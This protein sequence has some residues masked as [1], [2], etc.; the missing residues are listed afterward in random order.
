MRALQQGQTAAHDYFRYGLAKEI[1]NYLGQVEATVKDVYLYE[2]ES[3]TEGST[4]AE[5]EG[6]RRGC[7][8]QDQPDQGRWS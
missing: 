6:D 1:G 2:P 8:R 3:A 4:V 7:Q 5:A